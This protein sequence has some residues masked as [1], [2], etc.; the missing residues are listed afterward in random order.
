M[1]MIKML[2]GLLSFS[3]LLIDASIGEAAFQ[4][5]QAERN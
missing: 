5:F 4:V 1:F 2:T 3:N